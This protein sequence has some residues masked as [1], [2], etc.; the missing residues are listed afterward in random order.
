MESRIGGRLKWKVSKPVS[1]KKRAIK[2]V[3]QERKGR[4]GRCDV[5]CCMGKNSILARCQNELGEIE[6]FWR[7]FRS[8]SAGGC[9]L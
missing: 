4:E 8:S 7:G 5:I 6:G 2:L 1:A 9:M 3:G